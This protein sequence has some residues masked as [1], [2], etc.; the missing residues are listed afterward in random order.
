VPPTRGPAR[1]ASRR[2]SSATTRRWGT[3]RSRSS[4]RVVA[5]P[6]I[7]ATR[8]YDSR[9]RGIATPATAGGSAERRGS[10]NGS[11]DWPDRPTTPGGWSSYACRSPARP[12]SRSPRT[13][14]PRVRPG[15]PEV[16][17]GVRAHRGHSE[18][19]PRPGTVA[20]SGPDGSQALIA[21]PASPGQSHPA[22]LV[23]VN[24]YGYLDP[25]VYQLTLPTAVRRPPGRGAAKSDRPQREQA[26][27]LPS[28]I[29]YQNPAV[30]VLAGVTFAVTDRASNDHR[31][32]ATRWLRADAAGDPWFFTDREDNVTPLH[33]SPGV[34]HHLSDIEDP[35]AA[36]RSATSTTTTAALSRTDAFNKTITYAHDLTTAGG[37]DHRE[38]AV[39]CWSNDERE[40][41][42]DGPRLPS[43]GRSIARTTGHETEPYAP[44]PPVPIPTTTY[45]TTP[46]TS[47]RHR[48][49]REHHG[50]HPYNAMRQVL[51]TKDARTASPR[52]LTTRRAISSTTD[53]LGT[54]AT[55]MTPPGVLT[56]P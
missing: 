16:V 30:P 4:T 33:I 54:R 24:T 32:A 19:R 12:S 26:G 47:S 44:G 50:L 2:V 46:T 31:S 6:P 15:P 13:A 53:A 56:R 23:D 36:R 52:A 22:Q 39:R 55:P 35:P 18:L 3:S 11:S 40:R 20:R 8:T 45:T 41:P 28:G 49:P 9:D 25:A 43:C 10:P 37:R 5:D 38:G 21:S 27:G 1:R 48:R 34:P 17:L 42:G 51:T 14:R 29:W 7:R